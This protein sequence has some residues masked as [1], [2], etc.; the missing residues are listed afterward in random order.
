[1]K[2]LFIIV[3][4]VLM[5]LSSCKG[6]EP[7]VKN[8]EDTTPTTTQA[9]NVTAPP[10][11]EDDTVIINIVN[12][13]DY[14]T[15]GITDG[16]NNVISEYFTRY[17][18][19]LGSF[20]DLL[21]D[22]LY[23]FDT[24]YEKGIANTMI[25]YQNLIRKNMDIDLKYKEATV[26]INY[27]SAEETQDGILVYLV[28]NDYM[29]YNFI[30]DITSYTC[31]VEHKFLLKEAA[32]EYY[33]IS[34]SEISSVYTLIV[35]G[36]ERFLEEKRL[37]LKN[38]TSEQVVSTLF[39]MNKMLVEKV[40]AKFDDVIAQRTA[41]NNDPESFAVYKTAHNT[42]DHEVALE[43][44]YKWAGKEAAVRNPEY[45][46]YDE[47]GGNCNNFTS[48]ALYASGI[49]M[50]LYGKQWKW[51]GED[52]NNTGG[53]YGRSSSWAACQYFYEYCVENSGY[54]LVCET[55]INLY[56]GRPGD[57]IQYI[58]DEGT[59]VHTVIITNVICDAD[60]NV[61]DYLINSNTTDKVD[62][63][64]SLYG[65]TDFR[66]IRIIGWNN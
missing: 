4:T 23:Y 2:K 31:D 46:A 36:Y 13:N 32:G 51:Y 25:A 34:H 29:N 52:I 56:S 39:D 33:I 17:F 45:T 66:L 16:M 12:K 43:Y 26:G 20:K 55:D 49:P 5:V 62:C 37:T 42:Y 38:L 30:P 50:D 41:Y 1:M 57:L 3:L 18:T 10:I 35:E 44:S 14:R 53:R 22:D 21:L 60:G 7:K 47:Y 63:P 64:M 19:A 61:I 27:L 15:L 28:H 58:N 65:Y 8:K 6:I 54:G 24:E 48:Q 59:A 9:S 11:S 40:S